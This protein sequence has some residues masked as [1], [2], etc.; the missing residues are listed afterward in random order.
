ML[1][2]HPLFSTVICPH[3]PNQ[4]QG[5]LEKKYHPGLG[6]LH[7][8]TRLVQCSEDDRLTGWRELPGGDDVQMLLLFGLVFYIIGKPPTNLVWWSIA[9]LLRWWKDDPSQRIL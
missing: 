7:H 9:A 2:F 6:E 3:H 5:A 8:S 4:W 1:L